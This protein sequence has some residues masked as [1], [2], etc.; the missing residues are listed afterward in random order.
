MTKPLS[1]RGSEQFDVGRVP[2]AILSIGAQHM[3]GYGVGT[4]NSKYKKISI[5]QTT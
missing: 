3:V 1:K 2:R 5:T 4:A